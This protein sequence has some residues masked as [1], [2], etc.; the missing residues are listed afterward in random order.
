VITKTASSLK[1][2]FTT[3]KL[4]GAKTQNS[5]LKLI[6]QTFTGLGRCRPTLWVNR[7]SSHTPHQLGRRCNDV[8]C[9]SC[10]VLCRSCTNVTPDIVA[11]YAILALWSQTVFA[12]QCLPTMP[13]GRFPLWSLITLLR[14]NW[15][16][17]CNHRI[18][19][20]PTMG[21][22]KETWLMRTDK[23]TERHGQ[24]IRCSSLPLDRNF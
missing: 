15:F 13:L 19:C 8:T 7:H 1:R 23:R 4:H 3:R 5:S 14:N 21:S 9:D 12:L 22:N 17:C 6:W 18:P 2:W 16:H 10:C 20:C 11:C 24:P